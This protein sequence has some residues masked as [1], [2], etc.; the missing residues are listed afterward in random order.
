M[1]M[2]HTKKLY[3]NKKRGEKSPL[4]IILNKI[5]YYVNNNLKRGDKMREDTINLLKECNSGITM[6][7]SSINNVLPYVKNPNMKNA[8]IACK[9][10]HAKLGEKTHRALAMYEE[11]RNPPHMMAK[12]M[13]DMKVK[14]QLMMA[15]DSKDKQI[16][17]VMTDGCNMGI[18][19]IYKYLNKYDGANN[20][21]KDIANNI[22]SAEQQLRQELRQYL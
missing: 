17:G 12:M 10:K 3:I 4:F 21:T 6:G 11:S 13:A 8:L 2:E 9:E 22:I 18:K 19:S 16:A 5:L 14:A 1:Q 20:D 7:M 15:M